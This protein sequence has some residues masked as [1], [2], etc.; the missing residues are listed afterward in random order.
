MSG[1]HSNETNQIIC[2]E[3]STYPV[4]GHN[5]S[6]GA[7][8]S[9]DIDIIMSMYNPDINKTQ[10]ITI[11]DSFNSPVPLDIKIAFFIYLFSCQSFTHFSH[12]DSHQKH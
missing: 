3:L 7:I 10:A 4:F 2:L 9:P 6:N 5:I 1:F 12:Q 11:I 8:I